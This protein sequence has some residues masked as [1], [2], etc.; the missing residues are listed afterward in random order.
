M[1]NLIILRTRRKLAELFQNCAAMLR[2]HREKALKELRG[3]SLS[4]VN[5]IYFYLNRG[6][7]SRCKCH[8]LSSHVSDTGPQRIER[9]SAHM[10]LT[11]AE[12][13]MQQHLHLQQLQLHWQLSILKTGRF[14]G[15]PFLTSLERN[16]HSCHYS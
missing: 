1:R 8:T 12:L 14:G 16:T 5:V 10:W 7:M 15:L 11:E 4:F 13:Y 9:D 3:V 6:D 2:Y